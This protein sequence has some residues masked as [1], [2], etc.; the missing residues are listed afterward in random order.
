MRSLLLTL[1]LT[2]T[3]CAQKAEAPTFKLNVKAS[4]RWQQ[5]E[6]VR[7]EII[8]EANRQLTEIAN[9]QQALLIGA[10]VP[11]DSRQCK[12]DAEI[13]VCTKPEVAKARPAEKK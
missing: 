7:D 6:K 11:E 8:R 2:M 3:V 1:L 12:V 4:Q 10:D 13:V 9:Q 5:L